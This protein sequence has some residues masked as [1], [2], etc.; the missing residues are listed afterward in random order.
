MSNPVQSHRWQPSRLL[1]PWDSPGKNTGVGCHFPL[2]C[3]KVK[4]ESEI[5]QSCLT[6]SDPMDYSLPDSSIHGIFQ[7]RVLEWGAIASTHFPCSLQNWSN[8]R[9]VLYLRDLVR[10]S[11]RVWP[12]L[13]LCNP[14]CNE[15]RDWI[16][17]FCCWHHAV[18][19]HQLAEQDPGSRFRWSRQAQ[20]QSSKCPE[21]TCS[22][23]KVTETRPAGTYSRFQEGMGLASATPGAAE[24]SWASY[25]TFPYLFSHL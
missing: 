10:V 7:A 12:P 14:R 4:S 2:Q 11:I 25:L 23:S 24:S 18:W 9:T 16:S 13:G 3:M 8:C 15:S 22:P 20:G 1:C 6:L 19:D 5:A 21:L 17:Y